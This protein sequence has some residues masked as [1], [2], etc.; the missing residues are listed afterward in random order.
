[1]EVVRN[2]EGTTARGHI[3]RVIYNTAVEM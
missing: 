2:N 3:N 1:M